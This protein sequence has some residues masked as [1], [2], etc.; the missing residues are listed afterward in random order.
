MQ[1]VKDLH[2][3]SKYSTTWKTLPQNPS[4]LT[5]NQN[6]INRS[7]EADG[8]TSSGD[9]QKDL[10]KVRLQLIIRTVKG[11]VLPSTEFKGPLRSLS[12]PRFLKGLQKRTQCLIS[13]LKFLQL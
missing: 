13:T 8:V 1:L 6:P 5:V 2:M 7:M 3:N 4:Y 9:F 12:T 10:L 11:V